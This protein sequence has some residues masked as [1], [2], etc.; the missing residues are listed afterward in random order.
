MLYILCNESLFF[1]TKSV[2]EN[3]LYISNMLRERNVGSNQSFY[4][5]DT[6]AFLEAENI[7]WFEQVVVSCTPE[8]VQI[9]HKEKLLVEH[10]I[11]EP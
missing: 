8:Y 3:Y 4:K 10:S 9:L 6:I 7:A 2:F 5:I 1:K 11:A